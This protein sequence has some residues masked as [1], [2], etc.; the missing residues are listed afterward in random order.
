[1]NKPP[2][3]ISKRAASEIAD[4]YIRADGGKPS[5][6]SNVNDVD[7]VVEIERLAALDSIN[8]ETARIEAA[9]RLKIRASVLD[10]EV[11][12]KRRTLGLETDKRRR[13]RPRRKNYRSV[14]VA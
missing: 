2:R 11:T 14:A 9:D 10:R 4:K 12:K 5:E 3:T 1:M 6:P 13:P 7:R 8:Y